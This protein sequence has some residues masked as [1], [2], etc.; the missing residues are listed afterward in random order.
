MH[1][2]EFSAVAGVRLIFMF[3]LDGQLGISFRSDSSQ[4]QTVR[5]QPEEEEA[6]KLA[7][8]K[9]SKVAP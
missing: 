4:H 2:L 9:Y 7:V 1:N 3:E 5:Q 6:S 8:K